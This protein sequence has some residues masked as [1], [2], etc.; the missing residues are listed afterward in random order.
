MIHFY[1]TTISEQDYIT[2]LSGSISRPTILLKRHP[3]DTWI[4][5][6][7]KG[8]PKLWLANTDAQFILDSYAATSYCSSYMAKFDRTLTD[9]FKRICEQSIENKDDNI[10]II[11]KLGNALL[12]QQQMSSRQAVHIVL[13]FPLHR[14]S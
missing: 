13:S 7:A 11:H 6:F 14:S 4:N 10:Q 12:E 2:L 1:K 5:P 3:M 9:T 8:V